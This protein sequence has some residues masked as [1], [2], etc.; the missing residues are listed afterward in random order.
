MNQKG[1]S[2]TYI[3]IVIIVVV[4]A[5][6]FIFMREPAVKKDLIQEPPISGSTNTV[7]PLLIGNNAIYV[8]D[9]KPSTSV[10]VGF[11]ILAGGGYV[12]IHEDS[13]GKPGAIIGNSDVL[14]QGE[15]RDFDV[16]LTR[17]SIDDETLYAMLHSDNGDGEF[18]PAEDPPINSQ[19][20]IILMK[21]QVSAS[22]E[23][24][25]AISL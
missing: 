7:E 13:E 18:N 4:A 8:S 2:I 9:V 14:P 23:E 3:I 15:N 6:Y 12:V 11:A 25:G 24:P 5:A 17:E 21:F 22:A 10:K 1:Y 19:G 16:E 20:S